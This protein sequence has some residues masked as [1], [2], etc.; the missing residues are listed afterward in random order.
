MYS[1]YTPGEF[2]STDGNKKFDDLFFVRDQQ[3][4]S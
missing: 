2:N 1:E 4:I 3:I